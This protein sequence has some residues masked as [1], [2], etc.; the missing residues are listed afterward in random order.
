VSN[1]WVAATADPQSGRP[2]THVADRDIGTNFRWAHTNR[3][4]VFFQDRDGDENWRASWVDIDDG[5]I[6]LLTPEHG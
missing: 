4:I 3:H 6:R 5:S 1:L 2:L